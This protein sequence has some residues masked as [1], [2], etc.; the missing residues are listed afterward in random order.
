MGVKIT[1]V[2]A[3][4]SADGTELVPVSDSSNPKSVT[5]ENIKDYVVDS[6]E[7]IAASGSID[8]T[9]KLYSL[10]GGV[11]KP[12]FV[13]VIAQ[14]VIDQVWAKVAE[15]APDS[16]DII[17]LKD[18]GATEK[19]LT[20]ELLAEYVRATIEGS[21]LNLS[22]N[23]T[24]STTPADADKLLLTVGSTGKYITYANLTT[25]IYSAFNDYVI[26]LTPVTAGAG[27]DMM[28][29]IQ[30]GVEKSILLSDLLA[31]MGGANPVNG[32]ATTTVDALLQ[33]AD[34]VGT[35]KDGPTVG[36]SIGAA[37][38]DSVLAT[39]KAVRDAIGITVVDD[40]TDIGAAIVDADT[41]I[42]DDGGA[43][44]ARKSVV[45]RL[46][47]YLLTKMTADTLA[48]NTDIST[49]NATT[50]LHGLLK[51][52]SGTATQFMDG[53]GAWDTPVLDELAAPSDIVTLNASSLAHGLLPKLSGVSTEF[54]D[55]SGAFSTP[56]SDFYDTLWVPAGAM[57]PSVTDGAD[58]E[59]KEY[60][61]NDMTHDA[62]LFD[63]AA[64]NESAEFN[65][66]MPEIWNLGTVKAK[67]YWSAPTS[68]SANDWVRMSLAGGAF[69]NSDA[70]D[71][72]LGTAQNIDD[73][74]IT[75]DDLHI[76]AASSAITIGGTPALG[77]MIHFKLTRDYD[78][79]CDGVAMAEDLRFIG[80]LI[81]FRK[82]EVAVTW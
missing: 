40:L 68:A 73:Q 41:I 7:A 57:T 48:A 65:I 45:T 23:V 39:T 14:H 60:G 42:V 30:G 11:M 37:G 12:E 80:I 58:P 3:K 49:N 10:Q 36:T 25:A 79:A 33:W 77:D 13:S 75:I 47:T 72:V 50:L 32:P 17:A 62:L 51:K 34:T 52:L 43:G 81:Q 9:D 24:D 27:A 59:T 64:Q 15:P 29:V 18:G 38:S 31:Y 44:T 2:A 19:T 63:G 54:L 82:T 66:V 35:A 8:G 71:A 1:E 21:I 74:A 20:L 26:A 69:S 28:Y 46:V 53:T 5:T 16:A 76:S 55:G 6:I 61:T 22:A 67:M 78:Y 4:G 56:S 70:L